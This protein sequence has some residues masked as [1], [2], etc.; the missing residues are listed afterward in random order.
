MKAMQE[1][2]RKVLGKAQDI[3]LEWKKVFKCIDTDGDG[4]LGFEEFLTAACDRQKLITGQ[5]NLEQAFNILDSD[6]DGKL[7]LRELQSAFSDK[8]EQ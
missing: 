7:S 5:N 8:V 2:F 4:Q 6:K 3:K 1:K